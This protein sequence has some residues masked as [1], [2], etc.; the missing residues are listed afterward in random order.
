MQ[1]IFK[2]PVGLSLDAYNNM[3]VELVEPITSEFNIALVR[4]PNGD[5]RDAFTDELI[6]KE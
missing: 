4:F 6:I 3:P 1:L 5:E 2:C